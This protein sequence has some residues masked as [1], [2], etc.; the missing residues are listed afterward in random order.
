[1]TKLRAWRNF[2]VTYR[3]EEMQLLA[4]W[5]LAG[6]GCSVVG[7]SGCGRSNLLNFLCHRPEALRNYL[8]AEA[9]P[10]VLIPV[11]LNNLPANDPATFYRLL[12]R[13]FYWLRERF[14][15]ELSETITTLLPGKPG[16][17]RPFSL[18]KCLARTAA[19]LSSGRDAGGSGPESFF[20]S[21]IPV[22]LTTI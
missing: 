2:P 3:A 20:G 7:L 10:V 21:R 15:P 22:I 5:I 12:L 14:E 13:A 18:P 11:D 8:P 6:E 4:Q 16:C 9:D 19:P 1:M 17:S